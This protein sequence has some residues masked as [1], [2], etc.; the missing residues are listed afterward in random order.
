MNC[1][2]QGRRQPA[3]A[4]EPS[5]QRFTIVPLAAQCVMPS[6]PVMNI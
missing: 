2:L 4:F 1:E 3:Q 6:K 5:S